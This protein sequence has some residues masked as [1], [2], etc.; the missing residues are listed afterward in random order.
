M[1]RL[2]GG[3]L[4]A[5]AA[6]AIG[7]GCAAAYAA[8]NETAAP[9]SAAE[10]DPL[11]VPDGTIEDLQKYIDG[12]RSLQP[13]SSLRPALSEFRRKR[14]AA[15]LAACEKILAA[16][17]TYE[18]VRPTMRAKAA[19][20]TVLERLGDASATSKI[21]AAVAQAWQLV[22]PPP[23][24]SPSSP[25][26]PA[27]KGPPPLVRDVQFAILDGRSQG[28]ASMNGKQLD[29]LVD[30]LLEFL[31]QVPLDN[32]EYARLSV[33]LALTAEEH[34]PREQAIAIYTRLGTALAGSDDARTASTS[35]TLLGAARR[36]ELVGKPLLLQGATLAG[37]TTDLKKYKGKVVLIYFFATWCGPCREE[38]PNITKCY[39]AYHKRGFD[40][41]A[42]SIDRDRSTI[43]D[44]LD[45]EKYPWPVLLDSYESRGTEKSMATYY[46][47][48]T[49]PQMVLVG[50][51]GRVIAVDV[52]GQR[53]NKALVE[54][55]GPVEEAKPKDS[56]GT[57]EQGK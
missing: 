39:R 51:D 6:L 15:E 1:S 30:R 21:E 47:I 14:A 50:K 32:D 4:P 57:I 34:Q 13:S 23:A 49:I 48:F 7:L 22:P 26:P 46:G 25:P 33:D 56:G 2:T 24:P 18:Q 54:Q 44:F 41:L 9:L 28:A 40:V 8:D 12:L 17:P 10:K 35:A 20:L 42:V 36:L 53:L 16:K 38:M 52:R 27:R 55:L 43:A 3:I 29:L 11:R 5:L 45:K 31:K 19:A 37:R